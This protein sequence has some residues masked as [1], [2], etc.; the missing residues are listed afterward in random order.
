MSF[1]AIATN[2]MTIC[3]CFL[4]SSRLI[5]IVRKFASNAVTE[6][7]RVTCPECQTAFEVKPYVRETKLR[8]VNDAGAGS[9]TDGSLPDAIHSRVAS[10]IGIEKLQGFKLSDLFAEVFSKHSREEVED[11]FTVGTAKSTPSILEVDASWP[12]PWIFMR[13]VLAS[14]AIYFLF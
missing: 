3:V 14:L 7:M 4:H 8:A 10:A 6:G 2:D 5:R 11:Y 9:A 13:M 12:K 1:G